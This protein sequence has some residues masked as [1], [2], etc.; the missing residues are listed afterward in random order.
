MK[1]TIGRIVHF[2]NALGTN[3]IAA[4]ITAVWTDTCV[5]LRIFQDGSKYSSYTIF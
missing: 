5:N 4:I 1:P 3:P 2:V